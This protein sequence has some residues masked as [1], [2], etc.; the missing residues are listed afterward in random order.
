MSDLVLAPRVSHVL[1]DQRRLVVRV[2]VSGQPHL[3]VPVPDYC[4][5]Q[6]SRTVL[7]A[8]LARCGTSCP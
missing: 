8:V 1:D 4:L 6:I 2:F 3:D 5:P 7:D